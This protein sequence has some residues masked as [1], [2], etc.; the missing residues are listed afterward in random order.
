S[1]AVPHCLERR[2]PP[3]FP[4]RRSSDLAWEST[5]SRGLLVWGTTGG[6]ITYRT[7]T[8]PNTWG[9]ITNV[10]MGTTVRDWV[11]L[12][13]NPFPQPGRPK[14]IGAVLDFNNDLGVITCDGSAFTVVG[15]NSFTADA[16]SQAF[17]TFDLHD[18]QAP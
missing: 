17:Q 3:S 9:T 11:T 1:V 14:I 18:H 5:G 13:T 10:A 4:T 15:A 6:Q 16:G 2:A 12:R 7:F 8:A